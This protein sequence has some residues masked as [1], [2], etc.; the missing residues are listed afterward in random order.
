MNDGMRINEPLDSG[1]CNECLHC[2]KVKRTLKCDQITKSEKYVSCR[3]IR[4]C[5]NYKKA[6]EIGG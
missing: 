3:E 4:V 6:V 1:N 2:I 5:G